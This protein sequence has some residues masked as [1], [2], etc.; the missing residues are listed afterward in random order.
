L[1]TVALT[2]EFL[3]AARSMGLAEYDF[4][5]VYRVLEKL[6]GLASGDE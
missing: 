5:I 4:A 2:N 6:A 1:P 3:T